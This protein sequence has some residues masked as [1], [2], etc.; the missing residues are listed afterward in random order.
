MPAC[1]SMHT[2]LH[3]LKRGIW[4]VKR[5]IPE[6][7]PAANCQVM[8]SIHLYTDG[9]DQVPEMCAFRPQ[10]K[11]LLPTLAGTPRPPH[12][13]LDAPSTG[14]ASLSF[15]IMAVPTQLFANSFL[16][17]CINQKGSKDPC[18]NN[19]LNYLLFS[20]LRCNSHIIK[21]ALLKYTIQWFLVY[22][23][24]YNHHHKHF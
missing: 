2:V 23:E 16:F 5:P 7:L 6:S 19:F 22:S 8:A 1:L 3:D 9:L 14:G 4:N 21:L 15:T 17:F 24:L 12:L 11:V 18:N 10:C 20:L 13:T